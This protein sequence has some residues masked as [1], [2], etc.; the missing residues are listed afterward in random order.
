[1]QRYS[2]GN[3]DRCYKRYGNIHNKNVQM[4]YEVNDDII[5]NIN[6]I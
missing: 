4:L 6:Q 5:E 2:M 3:R 1:M